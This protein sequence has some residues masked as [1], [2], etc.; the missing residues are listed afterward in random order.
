MSEEAEEGVRGDQRCQPERRRD[1]RRRRRRRFPR[2]RGNA[3]AEARAVS[4]V[5]VMLMSTD[6]RTRP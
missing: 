1:D 5:D 4:G 3:T 2:E 6:G